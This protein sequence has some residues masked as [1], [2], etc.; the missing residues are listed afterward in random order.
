M[1]LRTDHKPIIFKQPV[2]YIMHRNLKPTSVTRPLSY[3]MWNP[4][5]IIIHNPWI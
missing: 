4:Y 2:I 3:H 5:Q 1:K